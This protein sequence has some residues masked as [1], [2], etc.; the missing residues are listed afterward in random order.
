MRHLILHLRSINLIL[1]AMGCS[2]FTVGLAQVPAGWGCATQESGQPRSTNCSETGGDWLS[3][4]KHKEHWIPDSLT[5]IKTLHVNFNIWQRA[6][7]T[8][9]LDDT[10]ANRARL[11]TV[12]DWVNQKLL[13]QF[14]QHQPTELFSPLHQQH[15]DTCRA[16]FNLFLSGSKY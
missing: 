11:H 16:G 6:D 12:I 9:N 8:G 3:T 15:P 5:P 2:F 13:D 1:L 10:P 14:T 4:Y 7:G